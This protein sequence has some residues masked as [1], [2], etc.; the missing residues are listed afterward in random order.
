MKQDVPDFELE[1]FVG[2][3]KQN[4]LRVVVCLLNVLFLLREIKIGI[5]IHSFF[6]S[7]HGLP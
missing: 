6:L 4:P 7:G 3:K 1:F 2:S 5:N